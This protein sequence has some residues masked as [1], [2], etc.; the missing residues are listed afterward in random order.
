MKGV[1]WLVVTLGILPRLGVKAMGDEIPFAFLGDSLEKTPGLDA[2]LLL[3]QDGT[4]V[5]FTGKAELGQGIKTALAQIVAD[6]LTLPIGRVRIIT[7][8]TA[9]TPDEGYT[10]GSLSVHQSGTALR[11]AAATARAIL[12]KLAAKRLKVPTSNLVL[13]EGM[14]IKKGE[15]SGLPYISLL[16]GGRFLARVNPDIPT[17]PFGAYRSVGQSVP[18]EDLEDIVSGSKR[19]VHDIEL[20]GM[21]YGAVVRPPGYGRRLLKLD[22]EGFGKECSNVRLVRNGSFLGVIAKDTC[23]AFQAAACLER[24]AI[25]SE[26]RKL[27]KEEAI[28]ETLRTL[29]SKTSLV[30]RIGNVEARELKAARMLEATFFKSYQA[31]ASIAPS[32][33]VALY[34]N[35]RYRVWTHSQGV[36]PL[37]KD[38]AKVLRIKEEGLRLSHVE[39]PGCYGHNGAD[40]V[41]L[42]ACLLARAVPGKP[43]KV[44]WSRSDEFAWEPFGTAMEVRL[45]ACL[46]AGGRVSVWRSDVWTGSHATRPGIGKKDETSL[47]ASHAIEQSLK[48]EPVFDPGGGE[49]NA[50]PLYAFE[51]LEIKKHLILEPPLRVSALRSL[52]AMANVF[53]IESFMDMLALEAQKDP[54]AFR[55]E[56]LKDERAVALILRLAKAVKW[57]HPGRKTGLGVGFSFARYKN[58][59]AYV[60]VVVWVSVNEK[61]RQIRVQRVVAGVDPGLAINPGGVRN[62]AEG[63]IVQALSMALKERVRFEK[64]GIQSLDWQTYPILGIEESPKVRVFVWGEPQAPSVGVGEALM[65][66]TTAALANAVFDATGVRPFRLPIV[67]HSNPFGL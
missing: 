30:A 60:A 41:A 44:L 53:A 35:G 36:F 2:W 22:E 34:E 5:A 43:L 20:P 9:L 46:D 37:R 17:Q 66:P 16:E 31:H 11:K 19:Y 18:R 61:T 3:A 48:R 55:I 29:K 54:V 62:Q 25:F 21:L 67:T 33:A 12:I 45:R 56:H 51:A 24:Y 57:S 10:V 1:G 50:L 65:G 52:G 6:E 32:A 47:I 14:V 4:V 58:A 23:G 39:G 42:D 26:P 59:A 38:L 27:P 8:D 28:E 49:R 40:D 63:G 13:Q 64:D 15:D 7:A